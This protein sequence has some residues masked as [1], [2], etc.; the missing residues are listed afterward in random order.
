MKPVD[1]AEAVLGAWKRLGEGFLGGTGV[2]P[3]PVDAT[4]AFARFAADYAALSRPAA[5]PAAPEAWNR[6]TRDLHALADRFV[7][8]AVPTWPAP[9]AAGA[10]WA[11]AVDAWAKVLADIST[12]TARRFATSLAA[13]PPAT[14][15][16]TF[17]RFIDSAEG[18]YQVAAHSDAF[19][20]A[21]ARLLN[22][23]VRARGRQQEFLERG[24]R[25]LGLPTRS[26]VDALYD[27][28]R[29]LRA[30]A[31]LPSAPQKR[32]TRAKPAARAK[33]PARKVRKRRP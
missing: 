15:R 5:G 11:S 28:L 13:D 3:G 14:L 29:E 17:D 1:E 8:S 7:G 30:T 23:F 19:I 33:P 9:A 25:A 32:A 16:A 6:F 2:P 20:A 10:E 18:A 4:A 27:Q 12:E 26:E 24:A 22:E 21:Q 31:P